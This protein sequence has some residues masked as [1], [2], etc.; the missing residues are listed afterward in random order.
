MAIDLSL[1][2]SLK[3]IFPFI[4][5][6]VVVYGLLEWKEMFGKDKKG[7]RAVIAFAV[8]MLFL[9][10][11]QASQVV[12]Y[13][14]PWF[15]ILLLFVMLMLIIFKMFGVSDSAIKNVMEK[16]RAVIYWVIFLSIIILF[17]ALGKV[18]FTASLPT[19]EEAVEG[20]GADDAS[21]AERGEGAF[22]QTLFHPKILGMMLILLTAT[23]TIKLLAG[24]YPS[25]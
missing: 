24:D 18:Y 11:S 15:I 20:I 14:T 1:L 13:M 12:E 7:V 17:A 16:D 10:S 23:F 25:T 4:L 5:V 6:W 3:R 19:H 2:L 8:A 21:I 9:V 22:W